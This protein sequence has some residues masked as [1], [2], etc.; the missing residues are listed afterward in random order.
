MT[1]NC[2]TGHVSSF[3]ELEQTEIDEAISMSGSGSQDQRTKRSRTISSV[4]PLLHGP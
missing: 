3:K 4:S 1:I 2:K